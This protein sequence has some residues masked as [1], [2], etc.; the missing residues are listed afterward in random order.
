MSGGPA[1]QLR[2]PAKVNLHLEVTGRRADGYH[3][4]AT[5]F[6]AVDLA[7]LL[8]AERRPAGQEHSLEVRADDARDLVPA[9]DDNLVLRAARAFCA[10]TQRADAFAFRL[11]KRIPSG[12]GLGGGSSD[13]AAALRLCNRLCGEPLDDDALV[14]VGAAL[15]ADVAFFVRGGVQWGCGVGDELSPSR[16]SRP[17]FLTLIVPPFGCATAAVYKM[18]AARWQPADGTASIPRVRDCHHHDFADVALRGGIVNDLTAAAEQVRPE[19]AQLRARVE[20]LGVAAAAMSGSGSTLF[21][22]AASAEA[23]AACRQRL[24]PLLADGVRLLAART[25]DERPP[26]EIAAESA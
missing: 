15:G 22:P 1:L 12:A 23:A 13:A 9:G 20:A 11:Q 18:H 10:R 4:L 5:L 24:A 19:L 14:R 2:A 16:L 25:A 17:L 7:D 26:I 8:V 21:V 3:L 6:A